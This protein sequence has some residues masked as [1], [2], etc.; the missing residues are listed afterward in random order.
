MKNNSKKIVLAGLILA[1]LFV[2]VGFAAL[3]TALNIS[4]TATIRQNSWNI[5]F[6]NISNKQG[7][8]A[9]TEP[10][11]S[12]TTLTYAVNLLQPG[13]YYEFTVDVVNSGSIPA[14][15]SAAPVVSGTSQYITHTVTYSDGSAI[16]A[17]DTLAANGG[18]RTLKVRVQYRTDLDASQLPTTNESVEYAVALTYVQA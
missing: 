13:D 17:N 12:G 9:T 11:I 7:V 6:S 4:G 8:S 3:R 1:I 2:T 15:L 14:K 18:K 10:S 5:A 16:N